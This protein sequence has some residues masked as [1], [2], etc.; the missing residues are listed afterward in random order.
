MQCSGKI[1]NLCHLVCVEEKRKNMSTVFFCRGEL[2]LHC[3]FVSV[4]A[5]GVVEQGRCKYSIQL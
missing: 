3:S 4:K 1:G 5:F 2:L